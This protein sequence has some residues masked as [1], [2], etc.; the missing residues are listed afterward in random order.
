MTWLDYSF[1]RPPLAQARG[2][3]ATGV[4]RYL[5]PVTPQTQGKILTAPERD[6]IFAADFDLALNFEWYE[7][8]CLEGGAAGRQD[9]ATALAQARALGYPPKRC[10]YFSH[11]TGQWTNAV[12]DYFDGVNAGLS[13]YYE[14]GGYG[15]YGT[16]KA[17]L[18]ARKITRAWQTLAWSNGQREPRA[19][20]YQN[21]RQW[22]GNAA[23]ENE[24][25]GPV[26]GW[27][28][29]TSGDSGLGGGVPITSPEDDM[30]DAGLQLGLREFFASKEGHDRIMI[31]VN[32]AI[33]TDTIKTQL[34]T[35][36]NL[37]VRQVLASQE[38]HDRIMVADGDAIDRRPTVDPAALAA[39]V[40]KALPASGGSLTP[41]DVA[42]AVTDALNATTLHVGA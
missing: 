9:A 11:D 15:G 36:A 3:G 25:T 22:F 38:G 34:T 32:D 19:A 33:T 12:L 13:G 18:D 20:L 2:M 37:A 39:A 17:L 29:I 21:G 4:L 30:D 40:V 8:R 5:A 7:G 42:K 6:L 24:V 10:I 14:T 31:A 1:S 35:Q 27:R 41:A 28:G 16:V 26:N 23:D